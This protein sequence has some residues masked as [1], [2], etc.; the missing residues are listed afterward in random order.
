MQNADESNRSREKWLPRGAGWR[1]LRWQMNTVL[2]CEVA[3]WRFDAPQRIFLA[4]DFECCAPR[5]SSQIFDITPIAVGVF[6]M[7]RH[8]DPDN[9]AGATHA[10]F[11]CEPRQIAWVNANYV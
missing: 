9:V 2:T 10:H 11:D 5:F 7:R 4:R 1:C 3:V 6:R 8:C